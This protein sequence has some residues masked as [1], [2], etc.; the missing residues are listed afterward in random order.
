M[1]FMLFFIM[2]S[3]DTKVSM[4]EVFTWIILAVL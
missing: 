3:Y 1:R 4:I 2:F